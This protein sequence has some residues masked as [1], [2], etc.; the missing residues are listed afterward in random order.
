MG[1]KEIVLGLLTV[2][3]LT[4]T[5]SLCKASSIP[6]PTYKKPEST[7]HLVCDG[8]CKFCGEAQFCIFRD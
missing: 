6:M 2:M 8:N 3:T 5:W 7:K 4:I 1:L